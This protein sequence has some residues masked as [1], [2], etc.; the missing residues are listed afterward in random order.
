MSKSPLSAAERQRYSRQLILPTFGF[1]GQERLRASTVLM[2]GAG[3]LGCAAAQYLTATGIGRLVLVDFDHVA[4]HN[5][6][7]Q[8][9]YRDVDV[10]RPKALV[11]A[12][13]LTA[14]NPHAS[15]EG[16][17]GRL[18][19]EAML[20]LM[21]QAELVLDCSDN[22][23]TREQLNRLCHQAGKALISAAAIR[24]EGQIAVFPMT[25]EAPCYYCLSHRFGDQPLSCLEAG[26]LAPV[27]GI[28]GAT[29]ALEAIKWLTAADPVAAGG[30][31]MLFDGARGEWRDVRLA[32]W[33]AC[34][35]CS[36]NGTRQI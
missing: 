14:L 24:L 32:K 25:P 11:A 18:D 22:L 27:V 16:I 9:L 29:Q 34:P 31:L 10:G 2:I 36:D 8:I 12:A 1:D 13:G 7:R 5:L 33:P 28:I 4:A 20:T 26:V 30:K 35:V 3:G 17:V 19:D 23:A 15:I 6:P 21:G